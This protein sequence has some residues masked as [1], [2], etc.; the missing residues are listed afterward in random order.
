M[1]KFTNFWLGTIAVLLG[2]IAFRMNVKPVAVSAATGRT[3][4][5]KVVWLNNASAGGCKWDT[6]ELQADGQKG[7][8]VVGVSGGTYA[9]G[10]G[11]NCNAFFAVEMR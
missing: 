3:Y 8:Q 10:Y 1:N 9:G 7:W 6:S 2:V 4:E 5:Y 11:V